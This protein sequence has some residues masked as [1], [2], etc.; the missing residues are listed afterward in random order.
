MNT[1]VPHRDLICGFFSG[2]DEIIKWEPT[3]LFRFYHDTTPI[4][5]SLDAL[6]PLLDEKAV[7]LLKKMGTAVRVMFLAEKLKNTAKCEHRI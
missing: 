2:K 5:A 6:I 1:G 3:D 4:Y 7:Y